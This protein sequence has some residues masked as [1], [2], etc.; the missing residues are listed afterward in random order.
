MKI[1]G[2]IAEL[3][4]KEM[5]Y[6]S[7]CKAFKKC[8]CGEK[9]EDKKFRV[10]CNK[11]PMAYA[12]GLLSTVTVLLP[13]II[14]A[15][16]HG[17]IPVIDLCRNSS[18]Q[19]LLQEQELAKSEN[20][21]EYY[22]TQP[23]KEISLDEVW[24]SRYVEE[25]RK[26]CM[27]LKYYIGDACLK[28]DAQ[29][30]YLFRIIC[31]N[32]HLQPSIENRVELEKKKLFPQ[33]GKVLGVGIR[34][35]YRAGII[36]NESILNGHPNVGSCTD[37]IKEIEKRLKEWNY[38][39]FFLTVDDRQYLEEIKKYFGKSCIYL[40]RP[41]THYFTDALRDIPYSRDENRQIEMKGLSPKKR[42]VDYLVELYLLAQCDSL[43]ASRGTG[44]NFAYLFNNGRYSRAEF[45]DLGE[46]Q[47]KGQG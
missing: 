28:D 8:S 12:Q 9:N 13:N 3:L 46:F 17:Y 26:D 30:Q 7:R 36:H 14:E 29:T 35:G 44:H 22:F 37:Y 45:I 2:E 40:E 5:G 6:W 31:E 1:I 21:W 20:A 38:D 34:A 18:A 24:Q 4:S 10:L 15:R 42:N 23:N 16:Q 47:Y 25:Q 11:H 32:I 33:N 41:R 43:Y 19:T 39:F 27:N